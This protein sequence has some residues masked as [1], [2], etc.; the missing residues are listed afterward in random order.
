V[1]TSHRVRAIL[2]FVQASDTG[3]FAAAAR[4]LGVTSAAVS[5]NIAGLEKALGVRL[6]NRTTRTL[7]LTEEGAAFLRQ[8]RVALNALDA[9]VETVAAQRGETYGR[10]RISTS[11]AIGQE[12]LMPL[13]PS[14][15]ARYPELS[16]AVDF[17]DRVVDLVR[18]GYDLALRGGLIRDSALISRPVCRL[19]TVLVASPAYLELRGVPR[20][21]GDLGRHRLVARRFLAGT[22][23][24]WSF[25]AQ[26]GSITTVDPTETAVLTLSAPEALVAAALDS[27][28]VAQVAVHLAWEHLKAGRLKVVMHTLHHPGSYEMVIQYPHRAL[29][30]PR[31]RVVVDHLLEAFTADKSLHVPLDSLTAFVA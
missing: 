3:S 7:N 26:D 11:V 12:Q 29:I 23:D 9:A 30:A 28:G 6:F 2:S 4:L 24:P 20:T 25:K 27:I 10:V 14:L 21:P 19:N 22:V 1:D 18:D 17:D 31:V 5:K 13:L 15:L 8:A 16:I